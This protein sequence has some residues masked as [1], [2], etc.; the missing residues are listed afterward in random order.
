MSP[1]APGGAEATAEGT[2]TDGPTIP[3]TQNHKQKQVGM[4]SIQTSLFKTGHITLMTS[5]K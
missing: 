5:S 2:F 3:H 1:G 4:P